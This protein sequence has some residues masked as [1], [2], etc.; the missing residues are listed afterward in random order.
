MLNYVAKISE[1]NVGSPGHGCV[2]ITTMKISETNDGS[3]LSMNHQI[4][5]QTFIAK[6]MSFPMGLVFR[7]TIRK[8]ILQDLNDIKAAVECAEA[9]R[10]SDGI[11]N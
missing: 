11:G 10:K 1:G 3:T 5:P 6:L 9:S 7:G 4:K 8:V 2:Y